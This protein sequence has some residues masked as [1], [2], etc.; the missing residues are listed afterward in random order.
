MEGVIKLTGPS[1]T[2]DPSTDPSSLSY[3]GRQQHP[4]NSTSRVIESTTSLEAL[5][6]LL[7]TDLLVAASH[8]SGLLLTPNVP[9][10][11][12]PSNEMKDVGENVTITTP[13][14]KDGAASPTPL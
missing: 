11:N 10:P 7:R 2:S 9:N 4:Y 3:K 12:D 1:R 13:I 14:G 5:T 8:L 6:D